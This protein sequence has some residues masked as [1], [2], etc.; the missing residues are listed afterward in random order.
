MN[1]EERIIA[2]ISERAGVEAFAIVPDG[3]RAPERFCTVELTGTNSEN[4]GLLNRRSVTVQSWAQTRDDASNL[5]LS[6][7]ACI[8][9]MRDHVDDVCAASRE[10]LVNFPDENSKRGRYQAT[11][12]LTTY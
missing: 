8:L 3:T 5:A 4:Y 1:I 6:V 7:D 9:G 11:Y 12:Q 10:S 2:Y